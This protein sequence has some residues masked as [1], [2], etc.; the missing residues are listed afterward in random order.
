MLQRVDSC[1]NALPT[2]KGPSVKFAFIK[3]LTRKY[4]ALNTVAHRKSGLSRRRH[5]C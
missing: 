1:H 5:A 4:L 2:K 3:S